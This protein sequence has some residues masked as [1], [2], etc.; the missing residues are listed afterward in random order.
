MLRHSRPEPHSTPP[1][2]ALPTRSRRNLCAQ[3]HP[4]V[5]A[6]THWH[7]P[8]ARVIPGNSFEQMR[9][10]GYFVQDTRRGVSDSPPHPLYSTR[11]PAYGEPPGGPLFGPSNLNGRCDRSGPDAALA[12]RRRGGGGVRRGAAS[13]ASRLARRWTRPARRRWRER[14]RLRTWPTARRASWSTPRRS[15]SRSMSLLSPQIARRRS[16]R[17]F[18]VAGHLWHL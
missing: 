18:R 2:R 6:P 4:R 7:P 10:E 16:S 8:R 15:S 9:H 5:D 13:A 14:R 12:R 11:P 1:H 3:A 17:S